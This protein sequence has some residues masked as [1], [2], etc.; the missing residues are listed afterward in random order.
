MKV[1]AVIP[2]LNV[3]KTVGA[4]V[5][6]ARRYVDGV[7]FVDDGS[8]DRSGAI[9]KS[10]GALVITLD[11]N[12]GKGFALRTGF[13]TAVREDAD[14]VVALDSDGQHYPRYIRNA[15][16]ALEKEGADV[17]VGSRYAGHFY[18]VPRNVIGNYGLNFIT[19]FFAYGPR[20]LMRHMWKG[21]TQS[22]FRAFRRGALERMN[23]TA[24]RYAIEGEMVYEAARNHLK[25]VEIP[26]KTKSGIRGVRMQDGVKNALFLFKK[27]LRL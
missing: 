6:E 2:G 4:V 20:G 19:N 12:Y 5:R 18:T 8:K 13:A 23:L 26:I 27:F 7:V 21:D 25:V 10:A 9:A 11:R 17:V 15:L 3:E 22:G 1:F 24:N 14:V 16:D